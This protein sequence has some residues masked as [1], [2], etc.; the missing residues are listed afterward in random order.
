MRWF[1]FWLIQFAF[2]RLNGFDRLVIQRILLDVED[3]P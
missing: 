1:W 3:K 2:R